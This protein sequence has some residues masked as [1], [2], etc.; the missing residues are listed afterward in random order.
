MAFDRA[1]KHKGYPRADQCGIWGFIIAYNGPEAV[2]ATSA[3]KHFGRMPHWLHPRNIVGRAEPN[4]GSPDG[5]NNN[6]GPILCNNTLSAITYSHEYAL[7]H[8]VDDNA[9]TVSAEAIRE[10][11]RH[12]NPG[13]YSL[14]DE[15]DEAV[16]WAP[17]TIT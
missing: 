6:E 10:K 3:I 1:T 4:F 16:Q 5:Y 12:D 15:Y 14:F 8:R 11:L 17:S 7:E 13:D 2:A 9:T